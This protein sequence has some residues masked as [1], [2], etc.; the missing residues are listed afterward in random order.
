MHPHTA[1][2][3]KTVPNGVPRGKRSDKSD[4]V[5]HTMLHTVLY[6]SL[7]PP[8]RRCTSLR[9]VL[10]LDARPTALGPFTSFC[11][12]YHRGGDKAQPGPGRFTRNWLSSVLIHVCSVISFVSVLGAAVVG[13]ASG[14]FPVV[15][16]RFVD[17]HPRSRLLAWPSLCSAPVTCSSVSRR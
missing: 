9:T 13:G 7:F 8:D 17:T 1:P 11:C 10:C 14:M 12:G 3:R 2:R 16:S 6:S 4:T 5:L 15:I